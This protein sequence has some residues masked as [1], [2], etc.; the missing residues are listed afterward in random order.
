MAAVRDSLM[1]K[2]PWLKNNW[3]FD[4]A[5]DRENKAANRQASR[6]GLD[7]DLLV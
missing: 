6:P 1:F 5:K 3:A 4:P 7:D 2:N